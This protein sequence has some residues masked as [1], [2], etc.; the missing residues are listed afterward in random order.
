MGGPAAYGFP[1]PELSILFPASLLATKSEKVMELLT[2]PLLGGHTIPYA[3]Q[4]DGMTS[5]SS[6]Y[7]SGG[8]QATPMGPI[9]V[10]AAAGALDP[11][12]P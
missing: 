3:S 2:S 5:L 6:A 7:H 10:A 9:F 1:A 11:Q 4:S 12:N 8:V